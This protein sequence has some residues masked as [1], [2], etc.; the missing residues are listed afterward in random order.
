MA[1]E[2]PEYISE[3]MYV[4]NESY[5]FLIDNNFTTNQCEKMSIQ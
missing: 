1:M 3:V 2:G 5:N 4:I